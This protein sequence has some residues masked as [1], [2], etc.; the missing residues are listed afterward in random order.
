MDDLAEIQQLYARYS[1]TL[2]ERRYEEWLECFA[3]DGVIEGPTFGRHAGREELRQFIAKYKAETGMFQVRH[4]TS[5]ISVEIEG[6]SAV[7]RCYVLH[8][9]THRGR[10][11]LS[12]IGGYRDRLRKVNG[13]WLFA[14]RQ[15]FWDYSGGSA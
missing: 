12:A 6:E 3:E 7:G 4:V 10:T 11:E 1:W 8:Y 13:Q 9:R 14:D 15:A 5:N 2:D